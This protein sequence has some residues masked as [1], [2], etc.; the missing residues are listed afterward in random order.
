MLKSATPYRMISVH[1]HDRNVRR[2]VVQSEITK[3]K[4]KGFVRIEGKSVSGIAR[5]QS[6]R[7]PWRFRVNKNGK[8]AEMLKEAI[9]AM[10]VVRVL[11]ESVPAYLRRYL[12]TIEDVEYEGGEPIYYVRFNTSKPLKPRIVHHGMLTPIRN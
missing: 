11:D 8:N 1:C 9:P 3:N 10:T 2:F 7:H 5:R 4:L 12:A 6:R